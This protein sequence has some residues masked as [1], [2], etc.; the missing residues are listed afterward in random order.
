MRSRAAGSRA[1]VA[2]MM[3]KAFGAVAK[4]MGSRRPFSASM[5]MQS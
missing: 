1:N 2:H 5:L 3:H 4:M